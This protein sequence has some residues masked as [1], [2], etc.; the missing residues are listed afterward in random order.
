NLAEYIT[1]LKIV[2]VCADLTSFVKGRK[3]DDDGN[4]LVHWQKGVKGIL[5]AS[6]ISIGNEN[7]LAIW[8][9]GENGALEW[10][11]E[12]PNYLYVKVLD[13]PVQVWC[14]GNDYIGAKSPA[15][16]RATRIPF[17]H[18]EGYIE[19]F[20]NIYCNFADTVRA[21]MTRTKPDPLALDF[22]T[23]GDGLRGMLFIDTL[24]AS[25]KT[26]QKWTRINT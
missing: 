19:A 6:Q 11:Q 20:A 16:A 18:P 2:E 26:K 13:G 23:V 25:A 9:Y 21:R 15:A 4:V 5:F 17:G 14:R 1:G 10:H 24:L 3:L 12:H 8:I 7:D 22:P